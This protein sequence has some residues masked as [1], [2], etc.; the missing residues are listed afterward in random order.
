MSLHNAQNKVYFKY[1]KRYFLFN[2]EI[3]FLHAYIKLKVSYV[4][5]VSYW[6]YT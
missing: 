4:C 2:H 5:I 3:L 6:E 1:F